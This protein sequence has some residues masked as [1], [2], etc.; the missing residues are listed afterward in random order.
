[1]KK[2]RLYS[3]G[4]NFFIWNLWIFFK[5]SINSLY[6]FVTKHI[7]M[8]RESSSVFIRLSSELLLL[9][10]S[11]VVS[12]SLRPHG[13]QPAR[14][15]CPWDFPGKSTGVG[16][17]FLL[18]G[19]FPTQGW[20]PHLLHWQADYIAQ[21]SLEHR[22]GISLCSKISAQLTKIPLFFLD[23]YL[24]RQGRG[25]WWPELHC[26]TSSQQSHLNE[27]GRNQPQ[28]A[29]SDAEAMPGKS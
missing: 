24:D 12:D 26:L 4:K 3:S 7:F 14:L 17:H 13:M 8:A 23:T 29:H 16:S 19:I 15:L 20:N 11:S 6:T 27:A 10:G 28:L 5:G 1:M 22:D 25:L 18:Q 2:H 21:N 9:F